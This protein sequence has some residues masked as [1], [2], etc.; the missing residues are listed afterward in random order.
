MIKGEE[1][2]SSERYNR[3]L[4]VMDCSGSMNENDA[5]RVSSEI[6][7]MFV[8]SSYS[9]RTDIGFLTFS[10]RILTSYPLT[11]MEEMQNRDDIK[12]KIDG[13][14][15]IGGTDIGMALNYG[16]DMF[17]N[18]PKE[19]SKP[20][21][22]FFSDGDTEHGGMID[23]NAAFEKS[24]QIGCP[25]YSVGLS[26][27][28]SLNT[29]Y[30]KNMSNA[31]GG[32]EYEMMNLDQLGLIFQSLYKDI[33]GGSIV[34]KES[35]KGT[36]QMQTI[37]I[38]MLD[39]YV[40]ESNIL[41]IHN[42]ALT[43]LNVD[44][45]FIY[46]SNNFTSVKVPNPN[47]KSVNLSFIAA[48][49]DKVKINLVNFTE[50]YP[51]IEMPKNLATKEIEIKSQLY[52][53]KA[54]E[55]LLDPSFYDDIRAELVIQDAISGENMV[56][57][58]KNTGDGFLAIYDNVNSRSCN[59]K[60]VAS[61]NGFAMESEE[62]AMIF[63]NTPPTL[64]GDLNRT[65]L[66]D[67]R[68]KEF[69]LND[70][71]KDADEDVLSFEIVDDDKKVAGLE[72]SKLIVYAKEEGD[73][74]VSVSASDGRGGVIM[75]K[76]NFSVVSVWVYFR[77]AIVGILIIFI[78][79]L[80]LYFLFIRKTKESEKVINNPTPLLINPNIKFSGA[81]FEGYFLNT[82]SGNDVPVLNWNASYID[83]K[84]IICLGDLFSISDVE[85]KLPESHKIFFRAGNN[86][87][88]IFYHN[89]EC[90]VS[91]SNRDVPRGKKEVLNYD[92]RLYIVFEDHVTEIEIRYKRVRKTSMAR[93]I[94]G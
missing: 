34:E 52:S 39:Y 35:V 85:E 17:I 10:N 27:D 63:S 23:E 49:D 91:L 8:D 80:I 14:E 6:V 40:D 42:E 58:M 79:L 53:L 62:T 57:E 9:S 83:S 75:G 78:L 11:P 13:I 16:M 37:T 90:L 25:I 72:N 51:K 61:K 43:D 56:L 48:K 38:D 93:A 47:G 44:V 29:E 82:L 66:K 24:K 36:G 81:R 70:F 30:L 74:L 60:V 84:H 45:G 54:G 50:V 69:D 19:G 87:T 92:D 4:F 67:D 64:N 77:N 5:N 89:T 7:K 55:V 73:Y 28:G 1:L 71:F 22:V 33:T 68:S 18:N 86:G 15:R 32:T 94:E 2:K 59:A 65:I 46:S 12:G 26:R 88:V 20:I 3:I 41:L 31:T 21:M 76:F